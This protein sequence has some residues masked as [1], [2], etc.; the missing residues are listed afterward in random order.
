VEAPLAVDRDFALDLDRAADAGR[1]AK[2]VFLCS[3]NNPTGNV[4]PAEH[5]SALCRRLADRALVVVDEA[6]AEFAAGPSAATLRHDHDNLVIL[7]TLSKAYALAGARVG[8]LIGDPALVRLLRGVLPPYPLPSLSLEA[9]ER[10]LEPTALARARAEVAA[11]V[12]RRDR[13]A[14]EL[15]GIDQIVKVWPSQ[16]NFLL[17]RFRDAARVLAACQANGVLIRDFS[18]SPIL[19]GCARITVGDDA[20][21]RVVV[22][23][24]RRLD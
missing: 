3:P 7:R 10:L 20:Q 8:I 11:T 17:V 12:A 2:V 21:N 6:Y 13:L 1:T 24:L 22:D 16:G 23:T 4:V 9:A 14:A 15:S 5:V 18:R 19:E